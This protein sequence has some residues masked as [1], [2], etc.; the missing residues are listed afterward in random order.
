MNRTSKIENFAASR[1]ASFFA[2]CIIFILCAFFASDS[3]G[4]I[5]IAG[6]EVSPENSSPGSEVT[7][8]IK[9]TS[10]E[11]VKGVMVEAGNFKK[12]VSCGGETECVREIKSK[13][14]PRA[15]APIEVR[16]SAQSGTGEKAFLTKSIGGGGKGS[17]GGGPCPDG[18][19]A[20]ACP[21]GD[22]M[23]VSVKTD[24]LKDPLGVHFGVIYSN[25]R[26]T[27]LLNEL[28]VRRTAIDLYWDKIEPSPGEYRWEPLD[29]YVEQIPEGFEAVLRMCARTFW[30][31]GSKWATGEGYFPKDLKKYYDFVYAAVKRTK[32]KVRYFENEFEADLKKHWGGTEKEYAELLKTFY[33]AVK[34]ANPEALV[35]MGGHSGSFV[36]GEPLRK[37][38]FDYVFREA[39]DSF[40]LV[41]LHLYADVYT[42]PYRVEWF[43]KRMAEIGVNKGIVAV[44]Y[45]GPTPLEIPRS[46]LGELAEDKGK[47][48]KL[49]SEGLKGYPDKI[50]M[51]AMDIPRELEERRDRLQAKQ[52][53]QRTLLGLYSGVEMML[54]W[55]LTSRVENVKG[56]KMVHPVFGKLALTRELKPRPAFDYY[57]LLVKELSGV[58]RVTKADSGQ[59]KV[60][61]FRLERQDGSEKY[62]VWEMRDVFGEESKP[63]A[64]V[65]K[66]GWA[67]LKATDVFGSSK[68][69]TI[70]GG[71][72]RLEIT[73]APVF[74]EKM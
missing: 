4:G 71:G 58:K 35:I 63:V 40:D 5:D 25:E 24:D 60:L 54:W 34:A 6:V 52:M 72:A 73:D 14:P 49:F 38:F 36:K 9:V 61:L 44:E 57:R 51:F 18:D 67:R 2:A 70:A 46:E 27:G 33:R 50:R 20:K 42:I 16:I 64:Y 10:P 23:P 26:F 39:K 45:G 32:G 1:G 7:L 65:F 19:V 59:D 66:T 31:P 68:E 56:R 12:Q 30:E 62:A 69:L 28:G 3:F 37:E 47:T 29:S 55:N 53:A 41:D 8:R 17:C 11:G 13:I 48:L 21:N 43:R 74:L 15:S 22:C